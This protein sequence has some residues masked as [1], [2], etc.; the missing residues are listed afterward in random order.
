MYFNVPENKIKPGQGKTCCKNK[1]WNQQ[2][3]LNLFET[4]GDGLRNSLRC[5]FSE[6]S[7]GTHKEKNARQKI[8]HNSG[9]EINSTT[10]ARFIPRAG[11]TDNGSSDLNVNY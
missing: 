6:T 3:R 9:Q 1:N 2:N 10:G 7:K 11:I 8:K 4:T 5:L